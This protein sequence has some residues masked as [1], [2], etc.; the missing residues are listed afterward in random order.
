MRLRLSDA[1]EGT[2][3]GP[4]LC[5]ICEALSGQRDVRDSH[6][7]RTLTSEFLHVLLK[8]PKLH[9]GRVKTVNWTPKGV[10]RRGHCGPLAMLFTFRTTDST[11]K[12]SPQGTNELKATPPVSHAT[13]YQQLNKA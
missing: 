1:P 3:S 9:A 6:L 12:K 5:A 7:V 10:A 4:L 2:G 13:F 11:H 8:K